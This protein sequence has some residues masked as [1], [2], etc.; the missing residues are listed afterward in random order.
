MLDDIVEEFSTS[1]VLHNHE[2]VGRRADHLV[3]GKKSFFTVELTSKTIATLDCGPKVFLQF[4]DVWV[5]EELQVL[6]LSTN[7]PHDIEA[8]DLLTIEDLHGHFMSSHLM[9][10]H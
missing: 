1:H 9:S 10:C 3:S 5:T 2:D 6:D 8:F 7:L 4:D